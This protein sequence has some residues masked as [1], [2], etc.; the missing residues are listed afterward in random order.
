M[1]AM[2]KRPLY[3]QRHI[4]R[5]GKPAYYVR[6]KRGPLI[7]IHGE[8]GSDEFNGNYLAAISGLPRPKAK[9]SSNSLQWLYERYLESQM[10]SSLSPA[11]RRQRANIFVHIMA[12]AG[13]EEFAKIDSAAIEAGLDDRK[14]TPAQARNYLD[15]VKGLFRWAKKNRHIAVDP[16]SGVEPPRRLRSG[17]G[18]EPWDEADVAA[19][20]KRWPVGTRQRVWFE[21]LFGSGLRRGDAVAAGM[22]HINRDGIFSLTTEKTGMMMH[23]LVE[24]EWM[25]AVM[26]RPSGGLHFICGERGEPLTKETFGNMFRAACNEAGIRKSAHGIRKLSATMDAE[27][28]YSERELEAKYGWTG[29]FMASLYTKS[30]NRKRMVVEAARRSGVLPAMQA[31]L[32]EK[33]A[34]EH[35]GLQEPESSLVRSRRLELPR[36]APLAPQASASTVPP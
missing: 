32:P 19:Y 9:P 21:V 22:Q 31:V 15:A 26:A 25:A 4:T 2:G 11:T 5:H 34:S 18:F 13:G 27:V 29:G 16:T 35:S 20:R 8:Y 10:W 12:K 23:C 7:R 17:Q 33:S 28:G 14:T 1:E 36:V 6:V 24:G 3:L 30:A